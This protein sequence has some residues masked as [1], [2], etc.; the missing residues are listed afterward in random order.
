MAD[1]PDQAP[2]HDLD[3][4]LAAAPPRHIESSKQE[5]EPPAKDTAAADRSSSIGPGTDEP[6]AGP[7]AGPDR[8]V[9]Q[10][11]SAVRET[12]DLIQRLEQLRPQI[13]ARDPRL[14]AAIDSASRSFWEKPLDRV[15]NPRFKTELAYALQDVEK[16]N[17]PIPIQQNIRDELTR[18]AETSPGLQNEQ[19]QK[20][21]QRTPTID[22]SELV[23]RLRD[24]AVEVARKTDQ[25]TKTIQNDV[26][27]LSYE[28][29][30]APR[31]QAA[32]S[33]SA[34]PAAPDS[35][36]PAAEHPATAAP[37]APAGSDAAKPPRDWPQPP[38]ARSV[39]PE[40]SPPTA[41]SQRIND[42]I[43]QM[44]AFDPDPDPAPNRPAETPAPTKPAAS[45]AQPADPKQPVKAPAAAAAA[46]ANDDNNAQKPAPHQN[47]QA[48]PAAAR[49]TQASR[50]EPTEPYSEPEPTKHEIEV[51][52]QKLVIGGLL[53]KTLGAAGK[54][55]SGVGRVLEGVTLQSPSDA[56]R[57]A[58]AQ[59][60]QE[61][62]R[63]EVKQSLQNF[64]SSRMKARRDEKAIDAAERSAHA[65]VEA[66]EAF[67][68]TPGVA[69]LNRIQEAA[70]NNKGGMQAVIEGMQD[71]G[72]FEDL[73]KEYNAALKDNRAFGSGYER[74]AEAL[75]QYG[76]HR[77]TI[78]ETLASHPKSAQWSAFFEKLDGQ[79]GEAA[80]NTPGK[81]EGKSALEHLGD[82]AREL[83]DKVLE[84][85]RSLF[86]HDADANSRAAPSPSPGP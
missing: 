61:L 4:K 52:Q 55:A 18:L 86:R 66:L 7:P 37:A 31:L 2:R 44:A 39:D 67:R 49:A 83:V 14:A 32:A 43:A 84:K 74:A 65:A 22:N 15:D 82:K 5:T 59:P 23:A 42:P 9:E 27:A 51:V 13:E 40:I 36:R 57:Q 70:K 28:V 71:G 79:V 35:A 3:P 85:I 47:S 46:P 54:A 21:L 73:R 58:Q 20:L 76:K 53:G 16:L 19:L 38:A 69:V 12:A 29:L 26:N 6:T 1:Q 34:H 48:A 77:E 50:P 81:K 75:G 64:E 33:A 30:V 45:P 41:K 25:N 62:D 60:Q 78:A 11:R 63:A 72:P 10:K 24:K 80:A 8:G 56:R 17:G 68:Q